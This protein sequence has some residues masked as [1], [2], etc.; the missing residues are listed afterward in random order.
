MYRFHWPTQ[1]FVAGT[2]TGL[3]LLLSFGWLLVV[4][5]LWLQYR[6]ICTSSSVRQVFF[7]A[8]LSGT[9][10]MLFVLSWSWSTVPLSHLGVDITTQTILTSFFWFT[11]SLCVGLGYGLVL[12]LYAYI[13]EETW[14][15]QWS[16]P[17]A[18]LIGEIFGRLFFSFYTIGEGGSLS[19]GFGFGHLGFALASHPVLILF[20]RVLGV[21]GLTLLAGVLA[22]ALLRYGNRR[23]Y[24]LTVVLCLYVASFIT[25]PF[26]VPA[27]ISSVALLGT[28]LPLQ[29]EELLRQAVFRRA[30]EE[31]TTAGLTTVILTE[32]S[33]YFNGGGLAAPVTIVDTARIDQDSGSAIQQT[34][35]YD[36]MTQQRYHHGKRA[37]VPLGEYIPL[38]HAFFLR[39]IG[40]ADAVAAAEAGYGYVPG[41]A[42]NAAVYPEHLPPVLFC[43]ESVV[44]YAVKAMQ[45]KG[46]WP[47]VAHVVSHAWFAD[48]FNTMKY[49]ISRMLAVQAVWGNTYILQSSNEAPVAI[50][51]PWGQSRIYRIPEAMYYQ[52][53]PVSALFK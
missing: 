2:L 23:R 27:H 7:G 19:I 52:V 35:T 5:G 33:R 12:A 38:I 43:Y 6:L 47:Y 46:D 37:L 24:L 9:I 11:G 21:Y 20:A 26:A 4:V 8:L 10:H 40:L 13:R 16:F 51:A 15:W 42:L 41:E 28:H 44:P 36:P 18:V 45:I 17:L 34:E 53:V 31:A 39:Q 32:D 22:L 50:Y 48:G 14:W 1:W 3:S 25:I 30:V 49:Q 29:S